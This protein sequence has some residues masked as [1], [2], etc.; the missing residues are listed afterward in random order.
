MRTA[1][2]VAALALLAAGCGEEASEPAQQ[3]AGDGFP[4]EIEHKFVTTT[5]E[6]SP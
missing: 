4:I 6:Q 3:Q 5:V 1:V 2:I